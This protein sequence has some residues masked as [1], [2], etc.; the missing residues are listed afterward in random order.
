MGGRQFSR[1]SRLRFSSA[2]LPKQ[3]D[4]RGPTCFRISDV[5]QIIAFA[6]IP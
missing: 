5:A 2:F 3:M 6:V 1:E 4:C